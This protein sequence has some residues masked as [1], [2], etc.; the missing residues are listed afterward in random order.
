MAD[1]TP[2]LDVTEACH[3]LLANFRALDPEEISIDQALGRLLADDIFAPFDLPPFHNSSMDGFAVR[4]ADTTRASRDNPVYLKIIAD[5]PAGSTDNIFVNEDQAARIMTGAPIPQ[6]ADAVIPVEF[7]D[8]SFRNY[9]PQL[10]ELVGILQ[11]VKNEDNIRRRG[12]DVK[13]GEQ[14]IR[15]GRRIQP[16]DIGFFSM[17]GI[18]RVSVYR[19]PRV[20]V[21]S[22][23]DE[24]VAPGKSL[25]HGKIFDANIYMLSAQIVK[26]GGDPVILGISPDQPEQIRAILNLAVRSNSDLIVSSAGVSVGAMDFVRIVL[27]E[28]G[29]LDFWRVNMRPGKPIA[30][31]HYQDIPFIG[32]PGN[33]VSAFVGFEVFIRPAIMKMSGYSNL[34]RTTTKVRLLEDVESD[35]REAYLRAIVSIEK[36]DLVARLTGHQFLE[37]YI[38][39][40]KQM[41]CF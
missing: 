40:C 15:A 32:L 33:P 28:H 7:T 38:P 34:I 14:V 17:L 27:K 31:G 25:G 23:G 13:Q 9:L 5:I 36:G 4:S 29:E 30:F 8:I 20:A 18:T 24:L 39:W 22:S 41:L 19:K 2:L 37:I 6:G 1:D 11:P 3:R 21:F 10:P 16:Q 12:H 26:C 35:G